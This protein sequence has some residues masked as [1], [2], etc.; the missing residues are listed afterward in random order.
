MRSSCPL[1]GVFEPKGLVHQEPLP[2][3]HGRDHKAFRKVWDNFV[4]SGRVWL[5][6][7][8]VLINAPMKTTAWQARVARR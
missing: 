3:E 5:T 2:I 1:A 8:R 6:V 7:N 4:F